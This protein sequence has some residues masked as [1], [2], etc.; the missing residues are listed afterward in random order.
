MSIQTLKGQLKNTLKL[1]FFLTNC[2]TSKRNIF[3]LNV[4]KNKKRKIKEHVNKKEIQK[5]KKK[6][7]TYIVYL[8]QQPFFFLAFQPELASISL[9][10]VIQ[11]TNIK[12]FLY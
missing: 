6:E 2:F 12:Q 10:P 5:D 9:D 8:E 7:K 4:L 1:F 11:Y 3:F